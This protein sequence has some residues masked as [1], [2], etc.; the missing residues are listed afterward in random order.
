MTRP[1]GVLGVLFIVIGLAILFVTPVWGQQGDR[2][3]YV[4]TVSGTIDLGMTPYIKRVLREAAKA[5]AEA[6]ILDINTPG[7]RLDAALEIKDAVL[8]AEVPVI[9]YVNREAFS[10][11]ALIAIAANRIYMAPGGV[12]GAATPVDGTGTKASEKVV[13]AVRTDFKSVAEFRG[14]DARIAEAMVDEEVEIVVE[15]EVVVEKGKLLT[16]TTTE[17]LNLEALNLKFIDG[18]AADLDAILE[19]EGLTGATLVHIDISFSERLVRFITNPAVAGI[20]IS[21]GFLGLL[22]ELTSPGFGV[23]GI[24]GLLL[25]ALFFWGH[26]LA[27]LTGWEGVALVVIGMGLIAIELLVIPGFG[28]AGILGLAVFFAGLF[29]AMIGQGAGSGD[30]LRA[31]LVLVG[32]TTLMII[33]A[34]LILK[35]L[36]R[37][38]VFRGLA[39]QTSLAT[40]SGLEDS[41]DDERHHED[42]SHREPH[43]SMVGS[44]GIAL[45]DL[46]PAG[47]ARIDN[48][49]VD[50]VTEGDFIEEGRSIEVI[51]DEEYRRV[52]K[53]IED[54]EPDQT[55]ENAPQT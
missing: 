22:A 1:R 26:M 7:G 3:V 12:I 14:R 16:L 45:T 51:A 53:L 27:E 9:A 50:V 2:E 11:G 10:A 30:F 36:P 15:G 54:P 8:G 47:I 55:E 29:M 6:V 31:A 21:L 32:S 40:G 33:G 52:V 34:Y 37:R 20:L 35:L 19:A 18:E 5:D 13:S 39:L 49:R 28:I 23:P 4:A 44:R 38:R 25:L 48:R 42:T 46:R 41:S 24:A 43:V 17:A